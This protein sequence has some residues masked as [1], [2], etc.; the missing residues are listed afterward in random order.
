MVGYSARRASRGE[1]ELARSAGSKAATVAE[2][3]SV[4]SFGTK[5]RLDRDSV[6]AAGLHPLE[7]ASDLELPSSAITPLSTTN[8]S[9]HIFSVCL[10]C[11]GWKVLLYSSVPSSSITL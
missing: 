8:R 9:Q 11:F 4:A 6:D 10:Y 1:M 7:R 3:A 5:L 2:T